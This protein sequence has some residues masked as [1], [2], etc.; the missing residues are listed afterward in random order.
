MNK[1]V[2][3]IKNKGNSYNVYDNDI[4]IIY[5]LTG[6]KINN[7]TLRIPSKC[8]NKV[9]SLL[10]INN[11]NYKIIDNDN[12]IEEKTYDRNYYNKY[13]N[14]GIDKYNN[15]LNKID[16]INKI[17]NLDD[18]DIIKISKYINYIIYK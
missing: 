14:M 12:I 5:S 7:N 2:N 4:Y 10:D 13:T 9:K 3:I 11:I 8:I 15:Y 17:N 1:C 6:Y 16:L 18:E